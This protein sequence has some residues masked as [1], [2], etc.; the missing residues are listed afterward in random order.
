MPASKNPLMVRV[1]ALLHYMDRA[2]HPCSIFELSSYLRG[3]WTATRDLVN[4]AVEKG[5][6]RAVENNRGFTITPPGRVFLMELRRVLEQL[7]PA[8]LGPFRGRLGEAGNYP[9]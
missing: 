4:R 7:D 6:V 9:K 1:W 5:W 2:Q 3:N 8:Q